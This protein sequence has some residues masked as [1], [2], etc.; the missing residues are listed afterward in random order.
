M[1]AIRGRQ[2]EIDVLRGYFRP[3]PELLSANP[4]DLLDSRCRPYFDT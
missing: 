2:I 3:G 4:Q 1:L